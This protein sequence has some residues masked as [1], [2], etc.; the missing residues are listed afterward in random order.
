M[1]SLWEFGFIEPKQENILYKYE[2]SSNIYLLL[3][4]SYYF[5]F[6]FRTKITQKHCCDGLFLEAFTTTDKALPFSRTEYETIH[7]IRI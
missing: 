1:L 4:V 5:V 7:Y 3:A 6:T 2:K